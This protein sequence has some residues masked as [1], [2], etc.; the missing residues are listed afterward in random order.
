MAVAAVIALAVGL[1]LVAP[2]PRLGSR[3]AHAAIAHPGP[4]RE[5]PP[6][7]PRGDPAAGRRARLRRHHDGPD[8]PGDRPARQLGLLALRQQGPADRRGGRARLRRLARA[9]DALGDDGR[10]AA[11]R[12]AGSAPAGRR[13]CSAPTTGSTTGGWACCSPSRPVPPSGPPRGS[14][15]STSA[16]MALERLEHVVGRRPRGRRRDRSRLGAGRRHAGAAGPAHPRRPRRPV[17]RAPLRPHRR[18]RRDAGPAGRRAR[19]GRPRPRDGRR[20]RARARPHVVRPPTRRRRPATGGCAC[21]ARPARSPRRA[22]TRAP[23]S[24]ASARQAG[25]PAS[26]LYWH[27]TDKDDLLAAVVEHSYTEW[28]ADQPA[29]ARPPRTSRGP[30]SCAATCPSAWAASSEQ[31]IFLRL[32][33]L[34]LLLRRDDPPAGAGAL[35]GG[36]PPRA[37]ARP[38]SGSSARAPPSTGVAGPASI[39]LM[40]LSDGLFFSNQLDSPTWDAGVFGDLVT[41][42]FEAAVSPCPSGRSDPSRWA[43]ARVRAGWRHRT[44]RPAMPDR[45]SR[46]RPLPI[47]CSDRYSND[48]YR[49]WWRSHDRP[50]QQEGQEDGHMTVIEMEPQQSSDQPV[51]GPGARRR[52]VGHQGAAAARHVPDPRPHARGQPDLPAGRRP[53]VDRLPAARLPRAE[54][55]RRAR[56]SRLLP[57]PAALRARQQR[58]AVPARR[59]CARPRRRT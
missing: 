28:F 45:T 37:A 39:A 9:C 12:R 55:L 32:G 17:P 25:L 53:Q 40:A 59:A 6:P 3:S 13:S 2:G 33:Y 38:A 47:S 30:T 15:S 5:L 50:R 44:G 58:A 31:P 23:A 51:D 14:G 27:F 26:S 8:H 56:R 11:P 22:A 24:R 49:P 48:H 19:R 1:R 18:R 52:P 54:R 41:R 4:G 16:R 10:L 57:G 36:P 20:P 43:R 34:L 7:A 46:A 29:W 42:L 21:C 35:H